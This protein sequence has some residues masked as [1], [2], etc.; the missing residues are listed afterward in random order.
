MPRPPLEPPGPGYDSYVFAA[1]VRDALDG[2]EE[3]LQAIM[4]AHE[5]EA[6]RRAE[7]GG[8]NPDSPSLSSSLGSSDTET[9]PESAVPPSQAGTDAD[10]EKV[11]GVTAGT[12]KKPR[13]KNIRHFV[14]SASPVGRAQ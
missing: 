4:R 5:R 14:R 13:A 6:R 9:S 8:S 10:K 3:A 11:L 7:P 12:I 1:R 2:C